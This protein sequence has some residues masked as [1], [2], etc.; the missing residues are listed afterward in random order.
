MR[1]NQIC[2]HSV[3]TCS[4]DTSTVEIATIMRDRHVGTV[5]VVDQSDGWPRP[6]GI[7]TERDLA[8]KVIA[9]SADPALSTAGDL[10]T[11]EVEIA[12]DCESAFEAICRMR[13]KGVRRLP[14][15]DSRRHL[16]GI[17]SVDD[18]ARLLAEELTALASVVPRQVQREKAIP[19]ES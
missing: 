13:A 7:V 16:I 11:Q 12:L 10:I 1:V 5:V 17:L 9:R 15:V 2:T 14:V 6:I 8:L 19:A 3:A 18:V 4:R